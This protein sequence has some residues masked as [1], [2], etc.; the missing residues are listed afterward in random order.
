VF[1]PRCPVAQDDCS[2]FV[3]ELREV[4][5]EHWV[6]CIQVGGYGSYR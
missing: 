3:P 2:E 4:E 5:P 6:S 1:H